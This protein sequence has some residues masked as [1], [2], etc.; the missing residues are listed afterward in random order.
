MAPGGG[1][2]Y[3]RG[4]DIRADRYP[5]LHRLCWNRPEGAVLDGREALA[6]YER[7]WRFVDVAALDDAER[8]LI[9]RL[10]R[11]HGND[12]PMLA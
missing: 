10:V 8:A 11:A 7:S 9:A 6:L 3:G 1:E 5:Q 12:A 4:M 2:P